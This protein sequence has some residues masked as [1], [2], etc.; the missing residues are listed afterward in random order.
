[1][2]RVED[3]IAQLIKDLRGKKAAERIKAAEALGEMGIEAK[4]ARGALCDAMLDGRPSVITAVAAALEKVDPS[5]HKAVLVLVVDNNADRQRRALESIA[6]L[7]EEGRPALS[8]VLTYAEHNAQQVTTGFLG[9]LFSTEV[10]RTLMAIAPDDKRVFSILT[11]CL[12]DGENL[13]RQYGNRTTLEAAAALPRTPFRK[14]SVKVLITLLKEAGD[15]RMRTV[16]AYSLG[17]MGTDA[18]D[19]VKYLETAK[20]DPDVQVREAAGTALMKIK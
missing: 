19:A 12:L 18:K 15:N 8:V 20:I 11:S 1:L 9:S 13:K 14:E 4:D 7:R 6:T 17:Q 3:R 2:K 10:I 5:L 16:A